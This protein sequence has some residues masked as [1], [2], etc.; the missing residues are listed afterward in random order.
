[1]WLFGRNIDLLA[2]FTPVWGTWI[3]LFFL[4][5]AYLHVAIPLW[6]WVVV[7]L[8][9]DVAH[10]WS[11]IFRTY[12]DKI[13]RINHKQLLG[14]APIICF[15]LL[16]AVASESVEWF[17]RILAYFAL[18][19][20]I[21]QQYGFF[22]LYTSR[23]KTGGTKRIISDQFIIYLAML[24][25]VF[26][27]H[28]NTR[29]FSWFID[30]DFIQKT[31]DLTTLWP[32]LHTLYWGV[33]V[34][35]ILEEIR[36]VYQSKIKL[37]LGRILWLVTTALNWY[38]GIVYFNSDLAFTLTNVVAHGIPYLVLIIYYQASK[39]P[40]GVIQKKRSFYSIATII[41]IGSIL[42]AFGEE[43]FWNLLI[44]QDKEQLFGN[45]ISYPDITNTT[46]QAAALAL[47]TLPQVV[48]YV[49]DGFIWKMN[50]SNPHL[51]S[52]I[53]SDE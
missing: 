40:V 7:I 29:N 22:A 5:P 11:T 34:L 20:F 10:V 26:F 32:L 21:K 42:L 13:E 9:I 23:A 6:G 18:F 45:R 47:L 39:K 50:S 24:Y 28:L 15:V 46:L 19:H 25:P 31:I 8:I 52:L 49:L 53:S 1:M 38:L 41:V 44:N 3:V 51:K 33:I 16:F 48:H 12:F 35:W 2:L 43:Y 14:L 36:L 37:S 17:W 30:G 27:W 4:P